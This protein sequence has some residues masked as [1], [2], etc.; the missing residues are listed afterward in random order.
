M[1]LDKKRAFFLGANSSEGFHSL[2]DK[3]IAEKSGFFYFIK[4]G[5]GCGKSSFMRRIA[6]SAEKAGLEREYILCSADPASLD[7][8]YFPSLN[9]GLLDATAPHVTE[10]QIAG[11]T[12][13][14][15]N[16]GA[17]YD[18]TALEKVGGEISALNAAYKAEYAEGYARLAATAAIDPRGF[19]RMPEGLRETIERR[20][21]GICSREFKRKKGRVGKVS[22]RFI[23]AVCGKGRLCLHG[24]LASYA[25]RICKIDNELGF[26]PFL[27]DML[28]RDAVH[29]GY[30]AIHCLSPDTPSK[31]LHLILPELRLAFTSQ[32]SDAQCPLEAYRHIRLDAAADREYL[33][34]VRPQYRTYKKA[35]SE[36]F[37]S[38]EAHL[39]RAKS[40][41]PYLRSRGDSG[42]RSYSSGPAAGRT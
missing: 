26:A 28:A 6:E 11:V 32:T 13:S 31:T 16:L 37:K 41:Q 35:Y 3:Y 23:D 33:R 24:T 30:D 15:I 20:A 22:L 7:G 17:F 39:A 2:Y 34:A 5:A 10:P 4:G 21:K 27:L 18:L 36:V 42:A 1:G 38:A 29:H 9:V 25:D 8:V 40:L 19:I 12:G 14:Y